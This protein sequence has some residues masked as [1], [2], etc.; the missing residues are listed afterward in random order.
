MKGFFKCQVC[1]NDITDFIV[2]SR[3]KYY[4]CDNCR[5]FN[6][7]LNALTKCLDNM[8]PTVSNKRLL[9]GTF[10]RLA[11]SLILPSNVSNG[12]VSIKK[13]KNATK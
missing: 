8:S 13:D 4:C 5:N 7:Y 9:R 11:N 2:F 1:G 6:K 12:T 10:F 3:P